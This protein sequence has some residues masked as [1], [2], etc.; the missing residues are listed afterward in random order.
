MTSNLQIVEKVQIELPA[1]LVELFSGKARYRASFGGRGSGK[2]RSFAIMAVLRA[3]QLSKAGKKGLIVCAREYMNSL[4]DSLR[5]EI[6]AAIESQAWLQA[7]FDIGERHIRTK[8]GAIAFN[9][10]GLNRNLSSIKSMANVHIFW[11]DEAE[12]VSEAAFMQIIPTI[13]EEDSE[14]WVSWNPQSAHSAVHKR[15][16]E[17]GLGDAMLRVAKLNWRDNPWFP[18]VLNEERLRDKK[19]RPQ[20]YEHIWEGGFQTAF[21][22]AYFA[23]AIGLARSE[24]RI[25]AVGEDPLMCYRSFWDI[26]GTGAKAD[27]TAIWVAQF[28]NHEMRVLDYYEAQGQPLATHINWLR[29]RGYGNAMVT[30]PHDG[31]SCDRVYNVSFESALGAAGFTVNVVPNQGAGAAMA[32]IEAAR[33]LFGSIWFNEA[34]TKAGLESLQ[35]Y[36]EKRDLVRG[37]GL[38]P[39][40]DW[41]SHAADA[42]GLMCISFEPGAMR[43][44]KSS[45]YSARLDDAGLYCS[46]WMSE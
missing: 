31:R 37:I 33:R 32:R 2:T 5:A 9:F 20:Y 26:G 15:F 3:Y 17:E 23:S 11:V 25:G 18:K 8:D 45:L 12:T 10:I 42:F 30:L 39:E 4:S 24:Q 7:H 21:V 28:I 29:S 16:R 35:W 14:I 36:H 1:K 46:S 43:T 44:S 13:R 22:G 19:L 40:H 38:G 27:A 34:T 6:K 41:S